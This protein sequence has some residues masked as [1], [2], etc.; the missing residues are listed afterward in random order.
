MGSGENEKG[1]PL[2]AALLVGL[3]LLQNYGIGGGGVFGNNWKF[4]TWSTPGSTVIPRKLSARGFGK[5]K[6][7]LLS[8]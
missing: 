6:P 5:M 4:C 1:P 2:L 3:L 8:S 7:T